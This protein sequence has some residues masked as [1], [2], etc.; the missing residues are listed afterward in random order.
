MDCQSTWSNS[1]LFQAVSRKIVFSRAVFVTDAR[2]VDA[3]DDRVT[4]PLILADI[5]C[6]GMD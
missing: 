5:L 3:K 4:L 2:M 1:P 6:S